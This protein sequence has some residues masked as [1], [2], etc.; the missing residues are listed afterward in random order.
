M[1]KNYL[2]LVAILFT[3]ILTAQVVNIPDANFKKVLTDNKAINTNS[4]AEI[5]VSEA[6]AYS[7]SIA[8]NSKGIKDLT[9]IE[10]FVNIKEL[11]CPSNQLTDLNVSKNVKLTSLDCRGNQLTTLDVSKNVNLTSLVC[12]YNQLTTLDVSKNINL[13][14]LDCYS[15]QLTTLDVS[16]NVNLTLLYCNSNQL[17]A[18][19]VS[20]NVNL[21]YLSCQLTA[22]DVSKN[23]N[24][25]K[26]YCSSNQLTTL[27]VSKN[28]NLTELSCGTNKLTT[29]DVSKNVN[30]TQLYCDFNQLTALDISKNVNLT[31]LYCPSNQLTALDASKNVNLTNLRC[32]SNQLTALNIKNGNNS[33]LTFFDATLN[34]LLK[35]IEV[36]NPNATSSDWK[37]DA[38]ANYSLKC[39]VSTRDLDPSVV[40]IFPNPT[41]NQITI[42]TD[43]IIKNY[44][45]I[46]TLG[47]VIQ[48]NTFNNPTL[49]V[50]DLPT[51]IYYLHLYTDDKKQVIKKFMVE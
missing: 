25:I 3:Q 20:K 1:K 14:S 50:S 44:C 51:G 49:N 40:A 6:I 45:I 31:L 17:T 38:T 42:T 36:D 9:G 16:K 29:L 2:L 23:V 22:L 32:Y 39:N 48:S 8:C 7:A 24:L 28:V 13:I 12:S 30:L 21:T 46:N 11:Y 37:K 4:D 43:V 18:L 35:C 5:Q 41:S 27:D 33:K 47:T 15:N 10:A 19:D 26:L 34:P